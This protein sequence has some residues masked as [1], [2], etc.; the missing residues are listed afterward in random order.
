MF[1]KAY[2]VVPGIRHIDL[3]G[4]KLAA[5]NIRQSVIKIGYTTFQLLTTQVVIVGVAP[6]RD[7]V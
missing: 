2:S 6:A 5:I 7:D 3:F 4:N 1:T